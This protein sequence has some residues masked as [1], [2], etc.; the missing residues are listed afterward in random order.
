MALTRPHASCRYPMLSNQECACGLPTGIYTLFIPFPMRQANTV[1]TILGFTS[2]RS[3]GRAYTLA[4]IF[5]AIEMAYLKGRKEEEWG[6]LEQHNMKGTPQDHTHCHPTYDI[7]RTTH[8]IYIPDTL[9]NSF[10]GYLESV[11]ASSHFCGQ[12]L[13]QQSCWL[14]SDLLS[15]LK[16]ITN[17]LSVLRDPLS[18][19]HFWCLHHEY[20]LGL[21]SGRKCHRT[22]QEC[23]LG[24]VGRLHF[25]YRNIFTRK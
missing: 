11:R 10:L 25:P 14:L 8:H 4:P 5:R 22:E 19:C 2:T 1:M 18:S 16:M 20:S 6:E 13:A 17:V 12:I 21:Q 23:V 24:K 3:S 7:P 15:R 9:Q